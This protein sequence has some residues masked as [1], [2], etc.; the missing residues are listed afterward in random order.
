M[1]ATRGLRRKDLSPDPIR[2]FGVW[3]RKATESPAVEFPETACLATLGPDRTPEAR[4]VLMKDFGRRGFVFFTNLGSGKARA[5]DAH[6]RAGMT[7]HWQPLGRQVR[8]RGSVRP[9]SAD[10][11]DRYFATRPRESRIGAW[12]S[13]QSRELA[14]RDELEARVRD[15]RARF[16]GRDVPR[17]D[18]WS[19]FRIAPDAIEFW[20]EGA[21]R[22]HDRFLY[23]PSGE[24]GWVRRRLYP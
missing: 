9:V 7:F 18:H 13:L 8:V 6:P 2:Q 1:S 24:G 14:S 4:M 19:G 21:S 5:I 10:E 17:P 23:L 20:Q 16:S 22:L 11:A 3:F 15:A 12:A